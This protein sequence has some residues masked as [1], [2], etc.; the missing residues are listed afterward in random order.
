MRAQGFSDLDALSRSA[1]EELAGLARAARERFHVAL[2]GG[3]TP[4]RMFAVLAE[5]GRDALPWDRIDLWWGDERCVPPDHADSNYRMTRETLID[6]LHLDPARV[7]RIAGEHDPDVA[8]AD[9]EHA[10]VTALGS[11]PIF[12]LVF[13][14][15]GPDGHTA[16]LFPD[17]PALAETERWCVA[18]RVDSPLTHGQAT[19][20]TLTFPALGAARRVRFLVA[21]ADKAKAL[22]RI[23][24]GE[25]LPAAR[26]KG[27]DVMWLVD[28]SAT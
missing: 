10:L 23:A 14:G 6:P 2:S 9:Y 17:S 27:S 5:M 16:S 24:A 12:D 7:H 21:G 28:R 15:M 13:L 20:I 26:V 25:E 8:A 3:S 19:R 22:A 11:P 1:A 18:N 4:K